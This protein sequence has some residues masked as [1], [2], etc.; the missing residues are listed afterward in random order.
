MTRAVKNQDEVGSEGMESIYAHVFRLTQGYMYLLDKDC[1]LIDCNFNFLT[2]LGL[3]S[4]PEK[5][6]G[7]LYK[8][9]TDKGLWT[10]N[11]VSLIKAADIN[12]I[13]SQQPQNDRIE[14]PSVDKKGIITTYQFSRI[15][16]MDNSN[17]VYGLLVIL[18][19]ITELKQITEQLEKVKNQLQ[20]QNAQSSS[21]TLASENRKKLTP[22]RILIVEDNPIAQKAAQS[23]LMNHDCLVEIAGNESKFYELFQPGKYDLVFMDI[24]LEGTSG[25]I[26]AK[27]LR[28][29]EKDTGHHVPII[30]L[31]GFE[32]N[33][34][35]FDCDYYQMEGVITK[36]LTT[37]QVKQIIQ[38]YI[39]KINLEV[40]GLTSMRHQ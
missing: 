5:N 20:V 24:G 25:Y 7:A 38:R 16:L 3:N 29:Q 4:L 6:I 39:F 26:M 32:A 30:A 17:D 23:I 33:V 34:V 35:Q 11:Q 10:E 21:S 31:T 14:L 27:Q 8:Q 18:N 36:P 28:L 40:T 37:E 15:P 19:D 2:L 22:P 1:I 13:L 9:M 12:A